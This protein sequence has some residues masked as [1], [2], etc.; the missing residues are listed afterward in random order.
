[1]YIA[2]VAEAEHVKKT[3]WTAGSSPAGAE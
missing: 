3:T 2:Y 1:V